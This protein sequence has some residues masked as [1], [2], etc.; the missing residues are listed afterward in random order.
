[1]RITDQTLM[2]NVLTDL[3]QTRQ[4]LVRAQ[5]VLASGREVQQPSDDPA[6]AMD[7]MLARSALAQNGQFH[8]N[9]GSGVDW[10]KATDGALSQAGDLMQ[11]ARQLVLQAGNASTAPADDAAL[12][13]EL[14][15]IAEA[16]VGTGNQSLEGRY[17][18]GG[19]QTLAAPLTATGSPPTAVTYNGNSG[20]VNREIG[21]GLSV[22]VN[23]CGDQLFTGA[24]GLLPA[25]IQAR[26]DVQ[27]GNTAALAADLQGIDTALDGLTTLRTDVGARLG[28]LQSAQ[29]G[30]GSLEVALT[31][32]LSG[33]EDADIARTATR[34]ATLNTAYQAAL[35]AAGRLLPTTLI[36]FLR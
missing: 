27:A 12:A 15:Q 11:R 4:G 3:D 28:R 25:L 36:D 24:A 20:S 2:K 26:T 14:G 35:N 16:V 18:F 29:T 22:A 31:Q 19:T 17:L 1:M 33:A 5:S 13:Q 10:L 6:R 34:Y 8:R 21:P 23:V 9:V 30:L 7:A 32:Q